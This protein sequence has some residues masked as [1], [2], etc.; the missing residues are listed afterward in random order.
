MEMGMDEAIEKP[1]T[2][3]LA[4]NWSAG[5]MGMMSMVRV[6]PDA[7]YEEVVSGGRS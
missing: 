4:R 5:M 6:L 2:R 1:E 7:R 3:G